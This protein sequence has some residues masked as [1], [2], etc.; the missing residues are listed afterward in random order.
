MWLDTYD[1][2][3]NAVFHGLLGDAACSWWCSVTTAPY[4][5]TAHTE[6]IGTTGWSTKTRNHVSDSQ[7]PGLVG[8]SVQ[9]GCTSKCCVCRKFIDL[10]QPG[11]STHDQR[12]MYFLCCDYLQGEVFFVH[13]KWCP[14]AWNDITI[15]WYD[16]TVRM[17]EKGVRE[18]L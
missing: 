8:T 9:S 10:N 13:R 2:Y 1:N 17:K 7:V 18:Q 5:H 15:K 3:R 16:M 6:E 11:S 12:F 4:S 14:A